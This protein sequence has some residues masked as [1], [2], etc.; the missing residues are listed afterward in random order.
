VG[1]AGKWEKAP[2]AESRMLPR[3]LPRR[4]KNRAS[5]VRN[6]QMRTPRGSFAQIERHC[7]RLENLMNG[8][9]GG[10]KDDSGLL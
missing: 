2:T 8:E 1:V 5:V 4:N 10:L 9:S 7:P 6:A 3:R